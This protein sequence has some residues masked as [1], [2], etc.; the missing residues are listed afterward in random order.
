[1]PLHAN[2]NN[3]DGLQLLLDGLER[4]GAGTK[5]AI[6]GEFESGAKRGKYEDEVA[7]TLLGILWPSWSS[8]NSSAA[9]FR[10]HKHTLQPVDHQIEELPI[11]RNTKCGEH[12]HAHQ[13]SEPDYLNLHPDAMLISGI[14]GP[15]SEEIV[16]VRIIDIH[17]LVKHHGNEP[18]LQLV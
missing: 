3:C 11:P 9:S 8:T 18:Y 6:H 2:T 15:S 1:M 10:V 5:R 7:G 12:Q 16:S 14:G 17:A 4:Q 13:L